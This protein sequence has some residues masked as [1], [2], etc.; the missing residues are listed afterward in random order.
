MRLAGLLVGLSRLADLGF[1]IPAGEALRAAALAVVLGRSLDVPDDDVRAALYTA[2]LHHAGCTGYAHEAARAVGDERTMY[3]VT[4]QTNLADPKEMF[5]VFLPGLTRGHPLLERARLALTTFT[6]G[7][8]I[9]VES[10]TAAC[11]VGRVAARRLGLPEGVQ[12]S[13]YR[14]YEWWNGKGVPDGL[15][16]DDIPVGARLAMLCS[17]V[18]L[19]DSTAGVDRAVE[20]ARGGS[21]KLFDP[22]L[23]DHFADR[24]AELLGEVSAADPQRLCSTPRPARWRPWRSRIWSRSPPCSATWPISRPR[25][26]MAT[27]A[28]SRRLP[29]TRASSS[30]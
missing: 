22:E 19:L 5:T 12:D 26:R 9:G 29:A 7:Q 15:E 2:L 16:G 1:G 13:I 27:R 23:A 8:R 14:S 11:E 10:T 25:T 3:A 18:A 24:A 6:R 28:A 30:V 17:T 21:G 20:V 4:A